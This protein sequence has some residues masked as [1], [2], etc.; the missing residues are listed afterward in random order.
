[1]ARNLYYGCTGN[2]VKVLQTSLKTLGY[3]NGSID[4]SFGP[5][6][7]NAV[8]N[9][10][11]ACG[12]I[13]DGI[14]GTQT[15]TAI[16]GKLK[17]KANTVIQGSKA[18]SSSGG[19]TKEI[20]RWHRHKFIVSPKYIYS[21][22]NLQVKASCELLGKEDSTQGYVSRKGGNP[23]EVT[24]T[25]RMSAQLGVN[26]R[27]EVSCLGYDAYYG[28]RDY[29][30]IGNSKITPELLMLTEAHA[31]NIEI[32]ADGKTWVSADVDLTFKACQSYDNVASSGSTSGSTGSYTG[33]TGYS[34]YTGSSKVSTQ[35]SAP[36]TTKSTVAT[37][38]VLSAASGAA[39]IAAKKTQTT[40][41]YAAQ[42]T[43]IKSATKLASA[44]K[45][46]T[47]KTGA[48]GGGGKVVAM[49]K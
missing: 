7:Y 2:D 30:Y 17:A 38:G 13:V 28:K 32:A 18:K 35:S 25:V 1:M 8:I 48:G 5:V 14:V 24:L 12:I 46:S 27:N 21:F 36:A 37:T 49:T 26:V 34:G 23:T 39:A 40:V 45:V 22:D 4:G 47:T 20:G 10:Q 6:T 15:A 16:A 44:S 29:F 43:I 31:K 9:F 11:K 3:Y 42:T 41:A 19:I 33:S